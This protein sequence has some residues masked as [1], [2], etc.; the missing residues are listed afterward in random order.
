MAA[1]AT[2]VPIATQTISGTSTTN[3]TFSSITNAYTDLVVIF[4]GATVAQVNDLTLQ[5]N[6]DS[7]SNYSYTRIVG[8]GSGQY[9]DRTSNSTS[10]SITI[11][12][13]GTQGHTSILHINNYANTNVYKTMLLRTSNTNYG[14][15]AIIGLWRNTSAINAIS[16]SISGTTYSSGS[17]F[18]LYG[19]ASA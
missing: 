2:Y 7:G 15:G 19:I 11:G 17:T 8:Y 3:V 16:I 14:P 13:P 6:S 10:I 1:G 18:T 5:F 4:E 9:S 12:S